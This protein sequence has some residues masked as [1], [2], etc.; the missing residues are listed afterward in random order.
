MHQA[1]LKYAP[2]EMIWEDPQGGYYFWCQLPKQ[3]NSSELFELCVKVG[4]VFMPGIPFFLEGNGEH[5]MRLNFTTSKPEEIDQGI[6]VICANIRKLMNRYPKMK[7]LDT[8][9]YMPV[10]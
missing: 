10:Y 1:L 9:S 3:V 7:D 6:S 4:I 2:K 5:Y 8:G